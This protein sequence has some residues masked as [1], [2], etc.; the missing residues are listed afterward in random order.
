[1]AKKQPLIWFLLNIFRYFVCRLTHRQALALGAFLGGTVARFTPKRVKAAT[2]RC[3]RELAVSYEEAFSVVKAAYRHFGMAAA[4]FARM[5]VVAPKIND[6]VFPHGLE[7]LENALRGGRGVMLI[8]A[9]IGNWEYGACWCARNGYA[10]N[11]LGADQRDDRLTDLIMELR[12]SGG[13]RALGKKNDMKAVYK[14]LQA[15]EIIAVPID[16]DAKGAGVVSMF[17]SNP[18]STPTGVAKLAYRLGC[19]VVPVFCIRRDEGGSFDFHFLPALRGRNGEPFGKDVQAAMDDCNDIISQWIR[20]YPNQ[21]LW[22]YPRWESVERGEVR[23]AAG[24]TR[25]EIR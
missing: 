11:A 7:N 3:S 4:E 18:A 17:L 10:L 20:K 23:C 14:A 12:R 21:W 1:M 6:I 9:H 24:S 22:M 5:P 15:K 2:R 16:Q 13:Y 8:T 25:E 19:A